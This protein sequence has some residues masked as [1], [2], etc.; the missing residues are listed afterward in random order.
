MIRCLCWEAVETRA[1][2][3]VQPMVPPQPKDAF[4][5]LRRLHEITLTRLGPCWLNPFIPLRGNSSFPG[6]KGWL[7][8]RARDA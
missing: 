3:E 8:R 7:G 5:A 4:H 6:M 1:N 2:K